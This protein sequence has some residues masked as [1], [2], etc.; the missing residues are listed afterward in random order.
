MRIRNKITV[1]RATAEPLEKLFN[2]SQA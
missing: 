1:H 2:F